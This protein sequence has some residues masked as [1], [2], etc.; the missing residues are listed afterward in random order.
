MQCWD[1]ATNFQPQPTFN[2]PTELSIFFIGQPFIFICDGANHSFPTLTKKSLATLDGG[3]VNPEIT[4]KL[5]M[6]DVLKV[7]DAQT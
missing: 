7:H 4:V 2:Q 5:E 3:I 6:R 1:P